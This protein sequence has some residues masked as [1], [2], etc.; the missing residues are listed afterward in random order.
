[1]VSF[2]G[3]F[4]VKVRGGVIGLGFGLGPVPDLIDLKTRA[5]TCSSFCPFSVLDITTLLNLI[6]TNQQRETT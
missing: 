1:M 5:C 2:L 3:S 4:R 6:L